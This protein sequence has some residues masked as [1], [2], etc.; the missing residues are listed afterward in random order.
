MQSITSIATWGWLWALL[1]LVSL[2]GC[3]AA[4]LPNPIAPPFTQS[5]S[6]AEKSTAN[7][8]PD[9]AFVKRC[10][11]IFPAEFREAAA[12]A[13]KTPITDAVIRVALYIDRARECAVAR[14]LPRS[15]Y[16]AVLLLVRETL[17]L[18]YDSSPPTRAAAM[19][20]DTSAM[21][22]VG[23]EIVPIP[24]ARMLSEYY[25][26]AEDE[27]R[28]LAIEGVYDE[29]RKL[30]PAARG[31]A[32]EKDLDYG[33]FPHAMMRVDA[34]TGTL[35]NLFEQQSSESTNEQAIGRRLA[36]LAEALPNEADVWV[37]DEIHRA[38]ID[39]AAYTPSGTGAQKTTL[40]Q[41]MYLLNSYMRNLTELWGTRE[42]DLLRVSLGIPYREMIRLIFG[43][44]NAT[45]QQGGPEPVPG[46]PASTPKEPP[47]F[48]WVIAVSGR[49]TETNPYE[50][51]NRLT[52]GRMLMEIAFDGANLRAMFEMHEAE[53][54][55]VELL[56]TKRKNPGSDA[57]IVLAARKLLQAVQHTDSP[58][59]RLEG[60]TRVIAVSDMLD[61][62]GIQPGA[63]GL[64]Q[65]VTN[66][67]ARASRVLA[68]VA[69]CAMNKAY[70][71]SPPETPC[72]ISLEPDA[73]K[74][75]PPRT[76]AAQPHAI[77]FQ[78]S[79]SDMPPI[80][81]ETTL[82][83]QRLISTLERNW[84]T[85]PLDKTSPYASAARVP[86][87]TICE[88]GRVLH[89]VALGRLGV[90]LATYDEIIKLLGDRRVR[91]PGD[92]AGPLV[93]LGMMIAVRDQR[94]ICG[95]VGVT[96]CSADA[97]QDAVQQGGDQRKRIAGQV[98]GYCSI[99]EIGA[100]I[101]TRAEANKGDISLLVLSRPHLR[102]LSESEILAHGRTMASEAKGTACLKEAK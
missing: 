85:P 92:Q 97:L 101:V 60:V 18:L 28:R 68:E 62:R 2:S 78:T 95:N 70:L 7:A 77:E 102:P 69:L 82:A 93:S 16:R 65:A 56:S 63:T 55:F 57:A 89:T 37:R 48:Q 31:A 58:R 24:S 86:D 21:R 36:I 20:G 52:L 17:A 99:A 98:N 26:Y 22:V 42:N 79:G 9:E 34:A 1:C 64:N 88:L 73:G 83:Y 90:D 72:P 80:T 47:N 11:T 32:L 45:S 74:E 15:D 53:M 19:A 75:A 10:N 27:L 4:P 35:M 94:A 81:E 25:L 61:G 29:K 13:R 38:G 66:F 8:V 40:K 14:V 3:A 44:Q 23:N 84:V 51:F 100:G 33:R 59:A 6:G 46:A 5:E 91:L 71:L 50:H 67:R 87:A 96:N 41:R 54:D 76:C 39:A 49:P 12:E 43:T 30:L